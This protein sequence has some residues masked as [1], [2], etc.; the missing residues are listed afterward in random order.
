MS[1]ISS[2]PR[3]PRLARHRLHLLRRTPSRDHD[4]RAEQ[5]GHGNLSIDG[6]L[7]TLAQAENMAEL[8]A[9]TINS[10]LDTL[11]R[12]NATDGV[13]LRLAKAHL[14]NAL[15]EMEGLRVRLRRPT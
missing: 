9:A 3:V 11:S 10:L 4:G 1:S 7:G 12:L 8:A 6:W 5:A 15:D 14:L 2:K 13:R